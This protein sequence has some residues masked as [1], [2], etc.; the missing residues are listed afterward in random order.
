MSELSIQT[1]SVDVTPPVGD[2]LCGGP[3]GISI[4]VETPL[5][6]RG[7]IFDDGQ[8]RCLI[9]S[10][11]YCYLVGSS[12]AR[13]LEAMA[14]GAA[15]AT[16]QVT[17]HATHIH[18]APVIDED[19]QKVV[20]SM[21]PGL[22]NEKSFSKIEADVYA[23]VHRASHS[24]AAKVASVGYAEQAVADFASYRRIIGSDGTCRSRWSICEDR[25]LRDAPIGKIDSM[26]R[27]V[28]FFGQA[29]RPLASIFLYASHPQVSDGRQLYSGDTCG[30]AIDLFQQAHPGV[31]PLYFTGCAGDITAGKFTTADKI[32]NREIFGHRLFEAMR[33]AFAK[34]SPEKLHSF[35][36]RNQ[37][38]QI[39]L[40]NEVKPADHWQGFLA[41]PDLSPGGIWRKTVA[42]G[43]LRRLKL[44]MNEYPFRA[45]RLRVNTTDILFLPAEMLLEYQLYAHSIAPG[46]LAVAAY[47]DSFLGYVPTDEC[48]VQGG[49]EADPM[50]TEIGRGAEPLIKQHLRRIL[51]T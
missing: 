31:F 41:N 30:L 23:A 18:D 8:A 14:R 33:S 32:G 9:A 48:F 19:A 43:K 1:F 15:L 11:E 39:P 44:Q 5:W 28:V 16:T 12:Y 25:T 10:I 24:P 27:S 45:S 36:W 17:L 50:C 13:L 46:Q 20:A 7:I 26:L 4:G 6:L 22:F 37:S 38:F 51:T 49:Y 35:S 21:V 3:R 47:G 40:S 29:D 2:Y 42:A 34:V